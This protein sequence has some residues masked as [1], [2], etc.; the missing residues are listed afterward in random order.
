MCEAHDG[1]HIVEDQILVETVDPTTGEV[2]APGETGELV[3]TTLMKKARPMIRFRTGDIG[4]VST[5]TCEC[6]RTLARIHVTGRKDEMFIVG[7]VNVFP[8]DVEYVVRGLRRASPASTSIR[9]Y[10]RTSPASYEV[11][12][13]R[14]LGSDEPYDEVAK[15]T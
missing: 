10:E 11:S 1:L 8:T 9:V 7:A 14:A 15:R 5:E 12:V 2:L 3:Y 6:G 4:Y 13:E